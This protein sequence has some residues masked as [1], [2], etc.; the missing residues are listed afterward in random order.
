MKRFATLA[1]CLFLAGSLLGVT[2]IVSEQRNPSTTE[3]II[4]LN[5]S[6]HLA[7]IIT[8]TDGGIGAGAL[9][10]QNAGLGG[11]TAGAF[12]AGWGFMAWVVC[13]GGAHVVAGSDT[14]TATGYDWPVL[15]DEKLY[16]V[17]QADE[18]A[19]AI[20]PRAGNASVACSLFKAK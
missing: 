17:L 15:G 3:T 2:T 7:G 5:G 14:V 12:D 6:P 16:T 8:V 19:I 11:N 13:D 4:M 1:V 18:N 9:F 10:V 20:K